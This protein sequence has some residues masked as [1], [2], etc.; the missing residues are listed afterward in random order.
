MSLLEKEVDS[1]TEYLLQCEY[2]SEISVM[3]SRNEWLRLKTS[4]TTG[5]HHIEQT[6]AVPMPSE[7]SKLEA[8]SSDRIQHAKFQTWYI[9]WL[10]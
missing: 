5:C 9:L 4:E 6:T 2:S 1:Y 3:L 7:L 8:L 10:K